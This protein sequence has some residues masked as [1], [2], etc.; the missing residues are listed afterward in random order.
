MH[1]TRTVDAIN[2]PDAHWLTRGHVVRLPDAH[3]L[4]RGHVVRLPD[5]HWLHILTLTLISYF[6]ILFDDYP[7]IAMIKGPQGCHM[8]EH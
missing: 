7:V 8:I 1:T 6:I 4:T 5:A 2:S 3:W